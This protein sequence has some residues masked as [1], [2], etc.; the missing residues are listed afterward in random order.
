MTR[1]SRWPGLDLLAQPAAHEALRRRTGTPLLDEQA[2]GRQWG[3]EEERVFG[4]GA[5]HGGRREARGGVGVQV[6]VGEAE[7]VGSGGL[8]EGRLD[9]VLPLGDGNVD[10]SEEEFEDGVGVVA[11]VAMA[12]AGVAGGEAWGEQGWQPQRKSGMGAVEGGHAAGADV[13]GGAGE[14][15]AGAGQDRVPAEPVGRVEGPDGAQRVVLAAVGGSGSDVAAE[16]AALA[17]VGAVGGERARPA[18]AAG[19]DVADPDAGRGPG[20]RPGRGRKMTMQGQDQDGCRDRS[21]RLRRPRRLPLSLAGLGRRD[22]VLERGVV[23]LEH[24]LAIRPSPA[25]QSSAE[26]DVDDVEAAGAEAEIKRGDVDHHLVALAHLAEQHFVGPGRAAL[27]A[28]RNGQRLDRDDDPTAQLEPTVHAPLAPGAPSASAVAPAATAATIPS[29]IS[30]ILSRL[31]AGT[32]SSSVWTRSVP[33]ASRT[34]SKSSRRKTLASLPPPIA[35]RTGSTPAARTPSSAPR[36]AR[37]EDG[38]S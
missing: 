17:Q 30:S 16:Q 29:Q 24:V 36:R 6:D 5:A 26:I 20:R 25:L 23:E 15:G 10:G 35:A 13:G 38:T 34:Q 4:Q 12:F 32:C 31:D 19:R 14:P 33:L 2:A 21:P 9:R 37:E 3:R 11:D 27:V 7:A 18:A 22:R 28:D 1:V 8:F